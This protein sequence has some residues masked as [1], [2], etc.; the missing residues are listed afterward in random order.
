MDP[1]KVA[2]TIVVKTLMGQ[3]PGPQH[4]SKLYHFNYL[5]VIP[6]TDEYINCFW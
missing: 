4:Y 3:Y 2:A 6:L 1:L 5:I